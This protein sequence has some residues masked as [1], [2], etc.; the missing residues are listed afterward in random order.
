ML[1]VLIYAYLNNTNIYHMLH[2]MLLVLIC[3]YTHSIVVSIINILKSMENPCK[4]IVSPWTFLG[5]LH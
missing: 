1:L 3:I 5:T 4:K 2:F